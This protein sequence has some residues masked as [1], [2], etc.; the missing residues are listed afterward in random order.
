[1]A[2]LYEELAKSI[3][4]NDTPQNLPKVDMGALPS[5]G[6]TVKGQVEEL[7]LGAGF[8]EVFTNGFHGTNLRDRLGITEGHPLWA[9]VET[10]NALDRGYGLVK[11]NA[12]AQA[13]EA[14]ASNVR[15]GTRP[16]QMYEWTRTFHP[17]QNAENTVCQERQLLWAIATDTLETERW[18]GTP[19]RAD[20]WF[21]KGLVDEMATS[22][23][24]PLSVGA[25][26]PTQPLASSLHPERQATIQ[27]DGAVVGILGEVHP[28]VAAAFKLKRSRPIFME[29]ARDAL[30]ADSRTVRYVERSVQQPIVR[31]LA[32]SLPPRVEAAEVVSALYEAGPAW[33]NSVDIVDLFSHEEDGVQMRA[34]TFSITYGNEDGDRS[35]DEV[36]QTSEALIAAIDKKLGPRGVTLRA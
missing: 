6:D 23:Q 21:F 5:H 34:V 28:Q 25:A 32:F 10:T 20:V 16:I 9:H 14:V 17:D 31:S 11:N 24:I 22:L 33:L 12:L 26:D 4:Y 19:R 30:E 29:I 36:N 2:D 27:L 3:G 1:V 15:A 13:V 35:A 18:A 8:Y 7:L